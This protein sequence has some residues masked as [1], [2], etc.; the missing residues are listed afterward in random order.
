MATVRDPDPDPL[1]RLDVEQARQ[2]LPQFIDALTDAVLILDRDRQI[3]AANRRYVE[4]FGH[5]SPDLVG[6]TCTESLNCPETS[7]LAAGGRCT[8]CQVIESRQPRRVLRSLP[9][10]DGVLRRWETSLNPILDDKGQVTH[11][12]EVWRDITDRR[13]LE[14]Q[15]AHSERLASLGILAAGVAH[16]INNP[17]AAILAGVE[18]LRRWMDRAGAI[19]QEERSEAGEVLEILEEATRRCSET[20]EKL[21]LL[22]QPYHKAPGWV[23]MNRTARDT[24]SL[25]GY[26][27]RQQK[28]QAMQDLDP[29]IPPIWAR[30]SGMRG[31]CMNLCMN[32]VQAMPRGGAL[33]VRTRR[34]GDMVVLEVLDTGVGIDPAHIDRIWD[35]FFTTKPVG[36]GTGLGLSVTH[37]VVTR[38]GGSIRVESQPGRGAHFIV[39]LPINGP[40]S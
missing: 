4:V 39:E 28:V 6:T 18:S 23:D 29:D 32:A 21:L 5:L 3:V 12:V 38:H 16:E 2:A 37:R 19:D 8:A 1:L 40:G 35:P 14:G 27:M 31:V 10:P 33:T 26:Q 11:V 7:R 30:E 20:T 22:A 24:L 13:H 25:L 15:L 17:M 9:D 34:E 36:Q